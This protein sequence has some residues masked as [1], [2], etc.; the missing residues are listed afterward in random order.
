[1]KTST[2]GMLILYLIF[3]SLIVP[4]MAQDIPS[5]AVKPKTE[6]SPYLDDNHPNRVL[7]GDTHLHTSYS[8]DAGMFG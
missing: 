1:M 3:V 4:S 5:T 7:W 6:Y 8:T 2:V